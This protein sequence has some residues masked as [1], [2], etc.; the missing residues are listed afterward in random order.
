[1][2]INFKWIFMFYYY[3]ICACVCFL[4]AQMVAHD[5][6]SWFIPRKIHTHEQIKIYAEYIYLIFILYA[7]V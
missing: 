1:M 5:T 6:P 2:F 7:C 4:E 3:Y